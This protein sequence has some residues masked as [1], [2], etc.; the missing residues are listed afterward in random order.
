MERLQGEFSRSENVDCLR[1]F[2]RSTATQVKSKAPRSVKAVKPEN[3]GIVS[4]VI[5]SCSG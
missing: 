1:I 5:E 3:L 2:V 4:A